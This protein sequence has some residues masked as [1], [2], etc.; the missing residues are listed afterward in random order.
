MQMDLKDA[1]RLF[2]VSERE[3]LRWIESLGAPAVFALDRY[4]FNRA[5][6]VDWAHKRGIVMKRAFEPASSESGVLRDAL[7]A[8]GIVR[9]P[10]GGSRDETLRSLVALLPLPP[11][12]HPENLAEALIARERQSSTGIG[13]GLA[14]PH[15]RTP[16]ILHT[17]SP[18]LNLCLLESPVDFSSPDKRPVHAFFTMIS[19]NARAHLDT[20]AKLA[21]VLRDRALR[22]ALE[23][24]ASDEEILA[25]LADAENDLAAKPR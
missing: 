13:D 6:L 11:G 12:A 5:E 10:G 16:L 9:L 25:A 19:P 17:E 7:L 3:M 22:T 18:L 24:R 14:I 20:I 23:R 21:S 1:S 15:V 4:M 2:D 8:G